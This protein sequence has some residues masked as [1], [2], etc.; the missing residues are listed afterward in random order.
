MTPQGETLKEGH[1]RGEEGHC[2]EEIT[3]CSIAMA[4]WGIANLF[5]H[6]NEFLGNFYI[7]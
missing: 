7:F 5:K 6:V 3:Y 4:S 2:I 1:S